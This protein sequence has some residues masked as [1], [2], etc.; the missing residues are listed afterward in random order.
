M[1]R[2]IRVADTIDAIA[3]KRA[4]KASEKKDKIIRELAKGSG[5]LY[6]PIIVDAG[7]QT[8]LSNPSLQPSERSFDGTYF[9]PNVTLSYVNTYTNNRESI[10]GNI[11]INHNDAEFLIHEDRNRLLVAKLMK[12]GMIGFIEHKDF[13]E[14][15]VEISQYHNHIIYLKSL[16]RHPTDCTFSL[17]W[18]SI[19]KIGDTDKRFRF[20]AN[21]IKLGGEICLIKMDEIHSKWIEKKQ[22][23][24]YE[25]Y[26]DE[27]VDSIQINMMLNGKIV[28]YYEVED[29]TVFVIYF[30]NISPMQKDRIMQSLF[31]KEI[32]SRQKTSYVNLKV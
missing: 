19:V 9:I 10:I 27:T 23:C 1:S 14:Y 25:I 30:Y 24:D 4:Y 28:N 31:R 22:S 20:E 15:S 12:K 29:G 21:L 17:V 16:K 18:E 5:L 8:I 26:L 13:I 3:S 32:L 7:I 2:I 11:L 6:D